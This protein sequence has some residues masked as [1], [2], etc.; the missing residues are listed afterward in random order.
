MVLAGTRKEGKT[1]EVVKDREGKTVCMYVC[2]YV[3]TYICIYV[4]VCVWQ[5]CVWKML[6]VKDDV[7]ARQCRPFFSPALQC[8]L[9]C[10]RQHSGPGMGWMRCS[11][12]F[13]APWSSVR[14]TAAPVLQPRIRRWWHRGKVPGRKTLEHECSWLSMQLWKT[15]TQRMP[16]KARHSHSGKHHGYDANCAGFSKDVKQPQSSETHRRRE[17]SHRCR[18]ARHLWMR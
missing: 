15:S 2:T 5:S 8:H 16:V 10:M 12:I 7:C 9:L 3:R 13:C 17:H 11:M 6:R 18:F 14:V 1:K 4:V